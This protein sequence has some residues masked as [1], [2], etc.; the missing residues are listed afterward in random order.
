MIMSATVLC[1]LL[2]IGGGSGAYDV[3]ED[4]WLGAHVRGCWVV[5]LL[6]DEGRT[7]RRT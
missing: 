7:G 6:L 2:H 1:L 5:D 3:N 4:E